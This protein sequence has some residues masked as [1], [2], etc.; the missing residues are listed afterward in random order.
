MGKT[1]TLEIPDEIYA[2]L[3]QMAAKSGEPVES[4]A[5]EWLARRLPRPRR[6]LSEAEAKAAWERLER[7]FGA[8]DS[9]DPHSADNERID[10]DLARAYS[11]GME[12]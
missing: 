9:G 7:H 12:G 10:A 1:V 11:E 8:I 5:V 4:L 6:K 2:A 3:E